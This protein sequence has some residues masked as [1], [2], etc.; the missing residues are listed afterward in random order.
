MNKLIT[1]KE[2]NAQTINS[3]DLNKRDD[4]RKQKTTGKTKTRMKV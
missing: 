1:L 2:S 3:T 4:N